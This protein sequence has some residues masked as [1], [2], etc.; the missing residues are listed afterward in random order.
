MVFLQYLQHYFLRY[1]ICQ[2][3]PVLVMYDGHKSH[4]NLTLQEWGKANNIISYVLPPHTSHATQPLDVGWFGPLKR[5]Y[6]TECQSYLRKIPGMQLNRYNIA[7]LSGKAYD[8]ART[9]DNLISSFRKA[10]ILPYQDIA[11]K[12]CSIT[13][14]QGD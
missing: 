11:R 12:N 1:V 8:R 7:K 6:Y 2:S 9:P 13:Y 4:I 10:G 3:A 5:A 14:I